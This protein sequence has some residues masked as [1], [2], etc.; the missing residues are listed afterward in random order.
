MFNSA[1]QIPVVERNTQ[2]CKIFWTY[3]S[4]KFKLGVKVETSPRQPAGYEIAAILPES[5][6]SEALA[7]DE[8]NR[9]LNVLLDKGYCVSSCSVGLSDGELR[10]KPE[11]FR[12]VHGS[13]GPLFI[14]TS[15][16][17]N[18][19][20]LGVYI[21]TLDTI[22]ELKERFMD[23]NQALDRAKSFAEQLMARGYNVTILGKK[24]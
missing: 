24:R 10:Y 5:Y 22:G 18:K 19:E 11:H 8:V 21:H 7:Q 13:S 6:E 3:E 16:D 23:K 17:I 12:E 1:D 14:S 9:V 4:S 15:F 20:G 2:S